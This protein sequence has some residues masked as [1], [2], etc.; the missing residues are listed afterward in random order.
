MSYNHEIKVQPE[1][2]LE[3]IILA[4]VV[5]LIAQNISKQRGK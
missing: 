5:R 2:S 1:L 3:W 4:R